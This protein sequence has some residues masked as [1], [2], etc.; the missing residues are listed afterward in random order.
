MPF[1]DWAWTK[2]EKERSRKVYNN[3]IGLVLE[4]VKSILETDL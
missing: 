2:K 3:R 4:N 1:T